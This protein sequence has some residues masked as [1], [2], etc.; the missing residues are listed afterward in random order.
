MEFKTIDNAHS[1]TS[2]KKINNNLSGLLSNENSL[3]RLETRA[4]VMVL[5]KDKSIEQLHKRKVE[6]FKTTLDSPSSK[7]RIHPS[8]KI[9]K[10]FD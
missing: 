1:N 5:N 9:L 6:K 7:P 4:V 3:E 2:I 8:S 10:P